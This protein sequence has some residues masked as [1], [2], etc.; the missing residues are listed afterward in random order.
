VPL[1]DAVVHEAGEPIR[2]HVAG[3]TE[4][5]LEVLEPA[6]AKEG[7]ADHEHR[8]AVA[9]GL[10][11]AGDRADLVVVRAREHSSGVE[12][13]GP[14]CMKQLTVVRSVSSSNERWEEHPGTWNAGGRF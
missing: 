13:S 9:D 10:E 14:R 2:Q 6:H 8:P 12:T 1:Q 11:R 3:H 7:V 5:A 4:V